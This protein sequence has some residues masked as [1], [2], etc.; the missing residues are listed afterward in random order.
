MKLSQRHHHK[1]K[2]ELQR[3]HQAGGVVVNGYILDR[4][5]PSRSIGDCDVKLARE[6]VVICD[7]DTYYV[8]LKRLP[9]GDGPF[10]VMGTDGVWDIGKRKTVSFISQ[11][12]KFWRKCRAEGTLDTKYFQQGFVDPAQALCDYAR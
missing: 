10:L 9:E 7:P 6:G 1:E 8:Q 2:G 11:H 3:I 12:V 5:Q 4:I